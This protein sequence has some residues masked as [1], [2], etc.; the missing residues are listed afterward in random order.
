MLSTW[1]VKRQKKEKSYG[2]IQKGLVF[3]SLFTFAHFAFSRDDYRLLINLRRQ[4]PFN[5]SNVMTF[6]VGIRLLNCIA[7]LALNTFDLVKPSLTPATMIKD[8]FVKIKPVRKSS[9]ESTA[10]TVASQEDFA[11][12][13]PS[14]YVEKMKSE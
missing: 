14:L 7:Y 3:G 8:N 2:A 12:D 10:S 6:A 1:V 11:H 5:T 13:E 9:D 4:I